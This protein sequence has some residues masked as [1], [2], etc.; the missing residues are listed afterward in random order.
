[1]QL[2]MLERVDV[3]LKVWLGCWSS[4]WE[5]AWM[6]Y[7]CLIAFPYSSFTVEQP[8]GNFSW[9]FFPV[10][11]DTNRYSTKYLTNKCI[12]FFCYVILRKQFTSVGYH[13]H[14]NNGFLGSRCRLGAGT[15]RPTTS[16]DSWHLIW[17]CHLQQILDVSHIQYSVRTI[18]V[19]DFREHSSKSVGS[20]SER[21][22]VICTQN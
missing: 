3:G 20:S 19:K 7:V 9:R 14:N 18:T 5:F 16:A 4:F 6:N 12:S 11:F 17:F 2:P 13:S 1:M 8:R 10:D 21:W 22:L 15:V